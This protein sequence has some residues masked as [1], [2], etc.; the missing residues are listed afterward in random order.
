MNQARE[1][2]GAV[3]G[4]VARGDSF[5]QA[6]NQDVAQPK[7]I[8]FRGQH[9]AGIFLEDRR[10]EDLLPKE[11]QSEVK[12]GIGNIIGLDAVGARVGNAKDPRS[13]GR[14]ELD[15][16]RALGDGTLRRV[17][18]VPEFSARAV[19]RGQNLA[20]G[21]EHVDELIANGRL[22]GV[23]RFR[24]E[25]FETGQCLHGSRYQLLSAA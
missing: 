19:G 20:L 15:D 10:V 2:F 21:T 12:E 7:Q 24:Q 11:F 3:G 16:V 14:I 17:D 8:P 4:A 13:Q 23:G 25:V 9:P 18:E 22:G 5:A 6:G 1:I